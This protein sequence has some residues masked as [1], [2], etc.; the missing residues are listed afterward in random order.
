MNVREAIDLGFA[1]GML[2]D[3]KRQAPVE[4]LAFSRRAVTNSLVAKILQSQPLS[5]AEPEKSIGTPVE[6]LKKR[7]NLFAIQ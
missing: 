1:D 4:A 3:E 5:P 2:E 7:L 6:L